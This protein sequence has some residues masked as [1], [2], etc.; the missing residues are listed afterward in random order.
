MMNIRDLLTIKDSKIHHTTRE[1]RLSTAIDSLNYYNIGALLVMDGKKLRGIVTERDILHALSRFQEKFF[2]LKVS[3]IMTRDVISCQADDSIEEVMTIMNVRRIRHLP[4]MDGNIMLGI[5]SI[6]DLVHAVL[7]D[8]KDH[9][10]TEAR[11][12]RSGKRK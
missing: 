5:I 3:D 10:S 7:Q 1:T 12:I 4:V 6:G 8:L 9:K 11:K 2:D